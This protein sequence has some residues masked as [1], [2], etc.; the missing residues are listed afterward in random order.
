MPIC[1][2]VTHSCCFIFHIGDPE[3]IRPIPRYSDNHQ[4]TTTLHLTP[5][6]SILKPAKALRV[7]GT[8]HQYHDDCQLSHQYTDTLTAHLTANE[9]HLNSLW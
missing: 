6:T 4:E 9:R 3:I 5:S 8:Y 2:V 1:V 7:I